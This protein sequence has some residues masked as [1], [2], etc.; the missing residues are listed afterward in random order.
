M[1]LNSLLALLG[2]LAI[3]AGVI[4]YQVFWPGMR[5]RRIQGQAFPA[6]WGP[7]LRRAL[8]VFPGLSGKQ[9]AQL[10]NLIKQFIADKQ[11]IGC[12]G[13]I[14]DDEIRV[15]IAANACLL[16]LNRHT[17]CYP[18]LRSVLVYPSTFVVSREQRDTAGLVTNHESALVGESWSEGK[19]I[20]AW[21]D[22]QRGITNF[23]DGHNVV[24]H[25]FAHELDHEDGASNG[26]PLLRTRG[27]YKNWAR[28]FAAEFTALQTQAWNGEGSLFDQYGA[29]NEAEFFAVATETFFERPWEMREH[30]GELY[31]ELANYY[32]V[33]P[34]EWTAAPRTS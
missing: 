7:L 2:L 25:E 3:L 32:Q 19:I 20:L 33:D 15:T 11:F 21:D 23:S 4:F 8:P 10:Q 1:P 13:Q 27:A 30:H 29:T 17:D 14:I 26:A 24:L 16:L 12:A 31:Q 28:V 18:Q 34:T 22:V 5:L 6:A 9:Q